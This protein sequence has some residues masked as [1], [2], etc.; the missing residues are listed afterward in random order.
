M[1]SKKKQ[2]EE[3]IE[4]LKNAKMSFSDVKNIFSMF[5]HIINF[6]DYFESKKY[7]KIK[8][9]QNE[10][11][12]EF[13]K[14]FKKYLNIASFGFFK[15]NAMILFDELSNSF[16]K[17]HRFIV[18]KKTKHKMSFVNQSLTLHNPDFYTNLQISEL[19]NESGLN[20]FNERSMDYF[21]LNN[22]IF[23]LLK[24]EFFTG[25]TNAGR[26]VMKNYQSNGQYFSTMNKSLYLKFTKDNFVYD[27]CSGS[28]IAQ[29]AAERPA[30]PKG[31]PALVSW[32]LH[33]SIKRDYKIL[34]F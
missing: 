10:T 9:F 22:K 25:P 5:E 13:K 7:D 28:L 16:T 15:S 14:K 17:N 23:Q 34:T 21:K 1:K 27:V 19:I 33:P 31:G 6:A 29:Q 2:L 24:R 12:Q 26:E 18:L 32:L 4:N 11:E 8:N 20:G 3:D 30:P